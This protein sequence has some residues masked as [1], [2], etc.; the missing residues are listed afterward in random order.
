MKGTILAESFFGDMVLQFENRRN[1]TMQ[2]G[3]MFH[4]HDHFN[5]KRCNVQHQE[6]RKIKRIEWNKVHKHMQ[7][8]YLTL[9]HYV[10]VSQAFWPHFTFT[11]N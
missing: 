7:M 5:L 1:H 9:S 10:H 11:Q 2:R 4:L 6:N 3:T 8:P